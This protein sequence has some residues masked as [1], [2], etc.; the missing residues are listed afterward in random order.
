MHDV[1]GA[2]RGHRRNLFEDAGGGGR[3][4]DA[5]FFHVRLSLRRVYAH[6]AICR[7]IRNFV[8]FVP[9]TYGTVLFRRFFMGGAIEEMAKYA[10]A[11]A[12]SALRDAFDYNIYFFDHLVPAPVCF[13][14]LGITVL[15]LAVV[16]AVVVHCMH[17]VGKTK[18]KGNS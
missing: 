12:I 3:G 7:G 4:G 15:V 1:R 11:E 10:P 14:I 8:T 2:F 17:K 9:G 16:F 5:G 13:A 6:L 18:R